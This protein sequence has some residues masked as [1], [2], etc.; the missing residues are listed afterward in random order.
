MNAL[1]VPIIN[2]QAGGLHKNDMLLRAVALA[3]ALPLASAKGG[4]QSGHGH[5]SRPAGA[6]KDVDCAVRKLAA[7]YAASLVPAAL[8]VVHS[9]LELGAMCTE[10]TA[11]ERVGPSPLALG[12]H[13]LT[14]AGEVVVDPA[15]HGSSSSEGGRVVRTVAEALALSRSLPAARRHLGRLREDHRAEV[16]RPLPQRDDEARPPGCR[17]LPRRRGGG[18]R[19]PLRG[20]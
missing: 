15:L 20:H 7:T 2:Y 18:A 1:G 16:R 4:T 19:N 3:I 13:V 6:P 5:S 10:Q 8:S 17:A 14:G 12:R 9:G 11:P